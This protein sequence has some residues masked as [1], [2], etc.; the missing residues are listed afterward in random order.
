MERSKEAQDITLKVNSLDEE[1]KKNERRI[2]KRECVHLLKYSKS[3]QIDLFT[4][5]DQSIV[6]GPIKG[7]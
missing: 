4:V 1:S 7:N 5:T 6:F 3:T 2:A